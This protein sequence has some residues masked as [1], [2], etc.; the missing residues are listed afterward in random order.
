MCKYSMYFREFARL[1]RTDTAIVAAQRLYRFAAS[2]YFKFCRLYR[3]LQ[4]HNQLGEVVVDLE[5]GGTI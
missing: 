4:F 3:P 2:K 5:D 1:D